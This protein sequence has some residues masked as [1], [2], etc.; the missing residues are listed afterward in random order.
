MVRVLVLLL[1]VSFFDSN[2]VCT[3]IDDGEEINE[4]WMTIKEESILHGYLM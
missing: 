1:F 3:K 2:F 4:G